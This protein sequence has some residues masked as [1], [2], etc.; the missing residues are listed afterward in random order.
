MERRW[1]T[2]ERG[3]GAWR[4]RERLGGHG[5]ASGRG[6][7]VRCMERECVPANLNLRRDTL[8]VLQR[9]QWPALL[10]LTGGVDRCGRTVSEGRRDESVSWRSGYR[11]A[12]GGAVVR[13]CLRHV[14][15][16]CASL[17]LAISKFLSSVTLYFVNIVITV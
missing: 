17:S 11:L 10:G 8:L 2:S 3:A 12:R 9:L 7:G 13:R 5:Q 4:G 14:A 1:P 15:W 16:P 6:R